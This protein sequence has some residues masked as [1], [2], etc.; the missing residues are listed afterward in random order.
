MEGRTGAWKLA[1]LPPLTLLSLPLASSSTRSSSR[2]N[3]GDIGRVAAAAPIAG[4]MRPRSGSSHLRKDGTRF[5]SNRSADNPTAGVLLDSLVVAPL[6]ADRRQW[7]SCGEPT[8]AAAKPLLRAA[9]QAFRSE[10]DTVSAP[11][12]PPDRA[13]TLPSSFDD[14]FDRFARQD[15]ALT[16]NARA[17]LPQ[18][19][20]RLPTMPGK[21][22]W[23]ME[24]PKAT[25]GL[26]LSRL[27]PFG[28][29]LSEASSSR[30]PAPDFAEFGLSEGHFCAD[31]VD[32]TLSDM[33][34]SGP[35]VQPVRPSGPA[36][37]DRG[38]SRRPE[39][40]R[41]GA[42]VAEEEE[43]PAVVPQALAAALGPGGWLS[44]KG[45]SPLHP[46]RPAPASRPPVR[47]AGR[48]AGAE[49]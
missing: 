12:P 20:N 17:S 33:V 18:D 41:S 47:A 26:N 24:S 29:Y 36:P 6:R 23:E 22:W 7:A 28:D 44:P 15:G 14:D 8:R 4:V 5:Y 27:Q 19:L 46:Q 45:L 9:T 39:G 16:S 42:E 49:A 31:R 34:M 40:A 2:D 1:P 35:G 13:V 30:G 21:A 10:G 38:R 37:A 43:K 11:E 25:A 3:S 48:A 32:S